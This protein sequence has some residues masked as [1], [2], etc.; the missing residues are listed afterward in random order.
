MQQSTITDK[1]YSLGTKL[2]MKLFDNFQHIVENPSPQELKELYQQDKFSFKFNNK[3]FGAYIDI[4][5]NKDYFNDFYRSIGTPYI[6]GLYNLD[7]TTNTDKLI[8][9]VSIVLRYDNKIWQ[10]MDLRISKDYRGKQYLDNLI[11]ATFATRVMKSSA[12]YAISM[13]PNPRIDAICNNIKLPKLKN[14]GKM[15]IYT[16]SYDDI[17]KIIPMLETFYCSE[18]GFVD[19]NNSR[20]FVD[21]TKKTNIRLLHLHHNADYREF[22]YRE[23]LRGY[24]YCFAI[25]ENNDFI[26]RTLKDDYNLDPGSTA[27]V[28]S[29]DFK[30][31][32]SRFVKTFEI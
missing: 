2:K 17:K 31:D 10:I 7:K 12:Y 13:N 29:N 28:F 9:T 19:N 18:I 16:V 5:Y 4:P 14:R 6:F 22:D 1:K 27:N 21:G 32:W 3:G 25:H 11:T 23:P 24:H 8:G 26:M 15:Y 30:A 20:I